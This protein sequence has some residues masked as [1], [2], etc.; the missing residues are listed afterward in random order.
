MFERIRTRSTLFASILFALLLSAC[1]GGDDVA[2][3]DVKKQAF[4]DLRTAVRDA[5]E[6][7]EREGEAVSLVNQLE[8]D[9]EA[10]HV[11]IADRRSTVRALNADYDTPREDFEAYLVRVAKEIRENR[12]VVSESQQALVNTITADEGDAIAR[13]H[14]RAM[15][16][17]VTAL[18]AI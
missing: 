3:A 8:R 16:A 7:P 18:Q 15:Q 12:Q 4:E 9:L 6:D 10:L 1:A 13:A 2:P 11:R 17:A 14:T 5:V